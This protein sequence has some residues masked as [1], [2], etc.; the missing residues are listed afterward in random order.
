MTFPTE[1]EIEFFK[2]AKRIQEEWEPKFGDRVCLAP[3]DLYDFEDGIIVYPDN[4]EDMV[5]VRTDD[6]QHLLLYLNELI[7]FP[8]QRQLQEML[9]ERGYRWDVGKLP[10]GY[11]ATIWS[12][13]SIV[14][15]EGPTPSIALGKCLLEVLKEEK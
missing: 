13:L 6:H 8:Y 2:K 4:A 5:V 14:E 15:C 10:N 9:E 7:W 3:H 11:T 12:D 1:Q